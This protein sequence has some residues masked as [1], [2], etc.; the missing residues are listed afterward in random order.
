MDNQSE[1]KKSFWRRETYWTL[2]ARWVVVAALSYWI[3]KLFMPQ[4]T[5]F[6]AALGLVLLI[7]FIAVVKKF[8]RKQ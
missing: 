5:A 7:I 3:L 8:L 4:T 1:T 6:W 2:T